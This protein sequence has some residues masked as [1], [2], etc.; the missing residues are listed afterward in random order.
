[1]HLSGSKGC[2]RQKPSRTHWSKM[3]EF[4]SGHRY[5]SQAGN[6]CLASDHEPSLVLR[7]QEFLSVS[8]QSQARVIGSTRVLCL[9]PWTN[10][11]LEDGASIQYHLLTCPLGGYGTALG[12][13]G[14]PLS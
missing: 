10:A 7:Q 13:S 8:I 11:H 12:G 4:V 9:P 1:M 6:T 14:G 5:G 3:G 2:V